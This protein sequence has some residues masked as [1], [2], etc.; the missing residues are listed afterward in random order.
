M[1]KNRQSRRHSEAYAKQLTEFVPS[2]E[3]SLKE[4]RRKKRGGKKR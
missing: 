2:Q 4:E 3:K 1:K